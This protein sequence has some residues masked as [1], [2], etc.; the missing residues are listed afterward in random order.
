MHEHDDEAWDF[1]RFPVVPKIFHNFPA[2]LG[3]ARA[4]QV[5]T[6]VFS[7]GKAQLAR[8]KQLCTEELVQVGEAP[9]FWA[10]RPS[11]GKSNYSN[12][13]FTTPLHFQ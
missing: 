2:I 4:P 5:V 6:S 1:L 8:A 11:K 13:T 7:D 12:Y 9:S 10:D 3:A